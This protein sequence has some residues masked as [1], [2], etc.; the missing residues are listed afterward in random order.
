ME[1]KTSTSV[2]NN[3]NNEENLNTLVEK[4]VHLINKW[5]NKEVGDFSRWLDLIQPISK[6]I[7]EQS[8]NSQIENIELTINI[9]QKIAEKYYDTHKD[10]LTKEAQDILNVILSDTG[11]MLIKKFYKFIRKIIKR[12]R[13][14]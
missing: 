4:C 6:I 8:D 3:D 5:T 11:R 13:Y 2:N 14:K 12:N 1:S 10:E 9:I 7:E